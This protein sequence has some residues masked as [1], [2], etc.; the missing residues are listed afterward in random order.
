[1]TR[2]KSSAALERA[3]KRILSLRDP[4]KPCVTICSGTGCHSY[5]CDKVS[6]AF[7]EEISKNGLK[8][9]IDVLPDWLSWFL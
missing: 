9:K 6:A 4:H 7:V 2:L 5:G 1:M 8:G 3:R